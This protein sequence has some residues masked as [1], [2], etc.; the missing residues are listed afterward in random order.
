MSQYFT[1]P[2]Q[3]SGEN[4][5]SKAYLK[6]EVSIDTS[7]LASKSNIASLRTKLDKL[8]VDN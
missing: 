4:Y 6:G 5:L 3:H 8:D 2:Y 1:K 7:M